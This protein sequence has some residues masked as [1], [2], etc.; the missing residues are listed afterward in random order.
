MHNQ[1]E[2][3]RSIIEDLL[4]LSRLDMSDQ[5]EEQQAVDVPDELH[6]ILQEARTLSNGQHRFETDIDD[7]LLLFGNQPELHSAFSNLIF[8]AIK[9]TPEGTRIRIGWQR[10]PERS[11]FL[12]G[13][14]WPRHCPGAPAAT[15]R[16]VL[17]RGPRALARIRR[18]RAGTGHRQACPESA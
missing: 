3:M 18:H 13:R 2:R 6:L 10:G 17:S 15:H 9:H 16:A 1:T 8:N 11:L 7:D 14:R 4:T 5:P 12:S